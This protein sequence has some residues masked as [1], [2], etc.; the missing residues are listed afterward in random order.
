MKQFIVAFIIIAT[1]VSTAYAQVPMVPLEIPVK[2]DLG[3]GG[4]LS[5]PLGTFGTL[6]GSG[7][8]GGIKARLHS[9]MPLNVVASINYHRYPEK[10]ANASGEDHIWMG[11][12]GLEYSIPSIVVKP[13]LGAD[14]LLNMFGST[15]P[16]AQSSTR[17]GLGIGGGVE[18][19]IPMFG[20][21]DA[22]VK[23]QI[24]NLIGKNAN[25]ETS[26]QIAANISVMLTIL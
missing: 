23:Y 3:F 20:S 17:E 22:S 8:H 19:A 4:G 7:W 25:E 9:V 26:A 14:V 6:E 1:M 21:F 18:F 11:C 10:T 15:L 5:S 2:L 24:L 16:N 12:A 13:Y